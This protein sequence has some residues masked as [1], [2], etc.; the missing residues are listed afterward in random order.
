MKFPTALALA[1]G[2]ALSGL[3]GL[4]AMAGPDDG[5][6]LVIGSLN[7]PRHFN[8]AIQTGIATALPATQIFAS[9]LRY[10]DDWTPQPYLAKSWEVSDDGLSVTLHLVDNALFHD[11]TPVTS[12]DVK[13]SIG[14]IKAN[15]P[16]RTMLAPVET[17]ET[18]DPLTVILHLSQPHPAL[19][20]SMSPNLMPIL[21][22]HIYGEGDIKTHPANMA[23]V[24]S[25]PFEF[26]EYKQSQYIKLKKFDRFFIEGRPHLDEILIQLF[27]EPSSMVLSTKNGDLDMVPFLSAPRD[28]KRMAGYDGIV[29]DTRGGEANGPLNWIA[30]N[31]QKPPLND[32]RVRQAIAYG[33]DRNFILKALMQGQA[34]EATGPIAP[35]SPFYTDE[36]ERYGLDLDKSRALLDAAGFA[37]GAD[38]LRFSLTMDFIPGQEELGRNIAEY[39]RSQL[40][41]IGIGIE[42][43]VAP[44][45]PTW[46]QR[47]ANYDFDLTED[48]VFNTGDPVLGVNRTYLSS[49]IRKGVIWSNTQQYSNPRVDELLEQAAVETDPEKRKALYKEFQQIVVADLPI[50]YL[51]EVPVRTARKSDLMDVPVGIW[52]ATAPMDKTYWK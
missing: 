36:V 13:F 34:P 21:P 19:L 31:T 51:N 29:I 47:V 9:P 27:S 18:P 20:L 6:T 41:K 5:G 37:P 10:D 2:L 12:E 22:K 14:I 16:F 1:A 7:V 45:F 8:M 38:G 3:S 17:V 15:H 48:V 40:K 35:G 44:D 11:G 49:N 28:I 33:I 52:G 32:L 43:R 23:P 39:L 46:A 30:F 26:V 42:V 25:G 24:G 50:Y 4:P